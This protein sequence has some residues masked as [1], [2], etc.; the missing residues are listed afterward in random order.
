[1]VLEVS[2]PVD[3]KLLEDYLHRK[4]A[5]SMGYRRVYIEAPPPELDRTVTARARRALR[6]LVPGFLAAVIAFGM[7][8]GVDRGV[9]KYVGMMRSAEKNLEHLK[10]QRQEQEEKER[11]SAPISVIVDPNALI[12]DNAPPLS[13]EAW[14][15]K[16]ESLKRAG[17]K[18]EAQEELK[19]FRSTYPSASP[20]TNSSPSPAA[21]SAMNSDKAATQK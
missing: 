16:I 3:D 12:K 9:T 13:R 2:E 4:S 19:K 1:L 8:L 6:W 20:S 10:Q 18:A 21:N 7:I 15:A 17:R 11:E 14:T 5:L